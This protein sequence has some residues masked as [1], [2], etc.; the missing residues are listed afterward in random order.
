[1]LLH[2]LSNMELLCAH[3]ALDEQGRACPGLDLF[4][5]VR[6]GL[7]VCYLSHFIPNNFDGRTSLTHGP[8]I[9]SLHV[10]ITAGTCKMHSNQHE[11]VP[12]ASLAWL[13]IPTTGS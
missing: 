4:A 11:A 9:P 10:N 12:T 6:V 7:D 8:I 3:G 5:D 13:G 1:M 2:V